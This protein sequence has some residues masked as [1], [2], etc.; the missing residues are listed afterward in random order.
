MMRRDANVIACLGLLACGGEPSQLEG[1]HD[2]S[3][4][5]SLVSDGTAQGHGGAASLAEYYHSLWDLKQHS[6]LAVLGRVEAIGVWDAIGNPRS[7][8]R[9]GDPGVVASCFGRATKERGVPAPKGRGR[10]RRGRS[11]ESR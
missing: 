11:A 8:H 9:L 2:A 4:N 6:D 5:P 1:P 7:G 10:G 3:A